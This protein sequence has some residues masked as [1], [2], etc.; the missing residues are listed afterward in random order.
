MKRPSETSRATAAPP[1][2]GLGV[3][4][5]RSRVVFC[6][7]HSV[8]RGPECLPPSRGISEQALLFTALKEVPCLPAESVS[9]PPFTPPGPPRPTEQD[10]YFHRCSWGRANLLQRRQL[11]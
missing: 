8:L 6:F 4:S 5:L 7:S 11:T 10:I 2:A 9:E 1:A 3:G